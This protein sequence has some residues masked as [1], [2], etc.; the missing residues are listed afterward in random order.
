[1]SRKNLNVVV[2][3]LEN[4]SYDNIL[5]GLYL[6]T[7]P[8][9]GQTDLTGLTGTESNQY[10]SDTYTVQ[11]QTA[12]TTLDSKT[13]YPPTC[14]PLADPGEVFP[15]MAQQILNWSTAPTSNPYAGYDR[16]APGLMG[17]FVANYAD[18]HLLSNDN[19]QDVMNYFSAAQFPVT[20]FLARNFAVCDDWYAS[21]PTQTYTNRVFA[22]CAAPAIGIE[23]ASIGQKIYSWVDDAQYVDATANYELPSL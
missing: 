3:M 18:Q 8:P 12:T 1:M 5:G 10:G 21:V 4:R 7:T 11:N 2:V 15:D 9:P 14:I 20:A 22:L 13:T 23:N 6:G 19:L 17:G 16:D